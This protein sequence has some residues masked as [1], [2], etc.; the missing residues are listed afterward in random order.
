MPKRPGSKAAPESVHREIIGRNSA[1]NHFKP[2]CVAQLTLASK[3]P[4]GSM[5]KGFL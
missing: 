3:A 4:D 1:A 2:G 5:I